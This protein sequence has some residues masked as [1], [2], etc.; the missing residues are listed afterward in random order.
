MAVLFLVR[1][2]FILTLSSTIS[3]ILVDAASCPNLTPTNSIKPTVASGYQMALVATGLTAPRSMEFDGDGNL[4]VVQ[5]GAGLINLVLNDGGGTCL[6]VKSSKNVVQNSGLNHGLAL[7]QDGKTLYASTTEAAFSWPY[8]AESSSVTSSNT[9]LVSG[10]STEDHTTRTLLMSQKAPGILV[11]SRGSTANIDPIA[12]QLSSGHSQIKAFDLGKVPIGGTGYTFDTEG[13]LLGWGLRNSVGVAEHPSTGGIYSVEN[14]ADQ[15]ER[16]GVDIHEDNPG[17]SYRLL[18]SEAFTDRGKGSNYGYPYCFAAWVPSDIPGFNGNVGAQFALQQN[19]TIN[20]TYCG[21]QTA[22]VITFQAHQA[23]IDIVFNNSGTEG[24][25]SF[26]GSWDRTEPAGYKVSMIPFEN[27]NPIAKPDNNT[28]AIDIFTNANNTVCPNNCFRPAGLVFD[29][30][31][32]LFVSSDASGE[33]Y[34][35][36]KDS[37][38]STNGIATTGTS[39]TPVATSSSV[40]SAANLE[41]CSL[42]VLAALF[43]L[44]CIMEAR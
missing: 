43:G 31:G 21:E 13:T 19:A 44:L 20:D 25:V 12:E 29:S 17:K 7:S 3:R 28:A 16:D 8:D 23:P 15:I 33:I 6:S 35:V 40:S 37:T 14:S 5:Q 39:S 11:I 27:G 38:T 9:T 24:W 30:Q 36:V 2:S 4:L 22:P 26:H 1:M 10:M 18:L 41:G 42:A 34:V 32:R